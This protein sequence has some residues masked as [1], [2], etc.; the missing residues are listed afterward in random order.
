MQI[1]YITMSD[2]TKLD[3]SSRAILFRVRDGM[4][5]EGINGATLADAVRRLEQNQRKELHDEMDG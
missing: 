5:A 4:K 1:D 3:A 2:L